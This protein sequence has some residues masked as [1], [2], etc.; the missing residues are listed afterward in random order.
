MADYQPTVPEG[1]QPGDGAVP[2]PTNRANY[3]PLSPLSFIRRSAEVYPDRLALIH[4]E[5]RLSWCE[6]YRRS[7]QGAKRMVACGIQRGDRVAVIAPNI[8]ALYE[9]HFSVPMCGGILN[10]IN[11]RLEATT[12]RY[13]LEHGGAS[14]LFV[15]CDSTALVREAISGLENPPL[16]IA[17]DDPD[18]TGE[19]VSSIDYEQFIDPGFSSADLPAMNADWQWQLPEDEWQSISLNYTSGTT[20]KPKGVIY[21]HRGATLNALSN[22]T[23][24]HMGPHPVYLWTLPMFHCNGWCFP[25]SLAA[26]AGTSICARSITAEMIYRSIELHKVTH[27]CGAPII[28]NFIINADREIVR[29][30]PHRVDIMTAAAPP[31]ASVL[32]RIESL[33]FHITHTYG[34]T[35][36]YGPAV[37]CA[38]NPDWDTLPEHERARLKSRQGVRYQVLDELDV[39]DPDTLQAV[40]RD[41][42]TIGEVMFRGNIVMRGYYKNDEANQEAFRGGWFHSGDLAVMDPDGYLRILDRSKDIIISGGEN[43]SSIE[44]E[45]TLY[46]HAAVLEAAVAARPD[47]KWG[48]TPCAFVTLKRGANASEQELIDWCRDHLAHFKCPKTIVF[49]DLPK[50]STGKIQKY[51]LREWATEL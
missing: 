34:L 46:A 25:W 18:A 26:N 45:D 8:P 27:F 10:A 5:R 7:M 24:W 39:L 19:P 1:C 22:I 29:T 37:M 36:T 11:T 38:W 4:G 35:E 30:L 9:L 47:D 16:L 17:I 41:G 31:P 28:L 2:L 44:I 21:H 12:V 14:I 51:K 20:G 50:T 49:R 6:T 48:E 15:D 42:T 13:I 40:P 23:G 32:S 33:G 43:I 3:A